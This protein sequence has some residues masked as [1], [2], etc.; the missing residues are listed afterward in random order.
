MKWAVG[1]GLAI[2]VIVGLI[3]FLNSPWRNTKGEFPPTSKHVGGQASSNS[4]ESQTQTASGTNQS[5]QRQSSNRTS[6]SDVAN[7]VVNDEKKSGIQAASSAISVNSERPIESHNIDQTA[8]RGGEQPKSRSNQVNL[9]AENDTVGTKE[10]GRLNSSKEFVVRK[11]VGSSK[12]A[13][14][15]SS[16][17]SENK[18]DRVGASTRSKEK[19]NYLR[20]VRE[21]ENLS[22]IA[23]ET[24]GSQHEKYIEWVKQNNP[25][26]VDPDIILPGQDIMLPR[27]RKN[28]E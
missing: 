9:Q 20:T 10:R 27:Y 6:F 25:Q 18:R 1:F 13:H 7:D 11:N 28:K 12:D 16:V 8:S 26:I 2:I 14:I 4:R 17:A 23:M 21:G 15:S 19:N 5:S 3:F 24:Y 22:K